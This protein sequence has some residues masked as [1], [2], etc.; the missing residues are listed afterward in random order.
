MEE[1]KESP[2]WPVVSV[3]VAARNEEENLAACLEALVHQDYRGKWEILVGD[4]Q[5]EDRTLHIAQEFQERFPCVRVFDQFPKSELT[6]GKSLIL[7]YLAEKSEGE[8]FL[9]CDADMLM[10][11]SW[12]TNMVSLL[13]AKNCAIVNGTTTVADSGIFSYLQAIDWLL[14]QAGFSFLSNFGFAFTAMGNNMGIT[15]EAYWKTGG[16]LKIPFSLT[17]DFALFQ[18]VEKNGGRLYHA[19]SEKVL[20]HTAALRSWKQW[21]LQHVRWMHGFMALPIYKQ[22]L[23]Y[24]FLALYPLAFLS[25]LTKDF[26]GGLWWISLFI[27]KFLQ[28][29]WQLSRIGRVELLLYLPVYQLIWWPFYMACWLS[30]GFSPRIEW[31]GRQWDN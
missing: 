5:S 22:S 27:L 13:Q 14:P 31:K 26:P 16:Y 7:G 6:A 3:W 29:A 25:L 9:I 28:D 21:L 30:Y 8:I 2:K 23:L 20:G 24:G 19:Y 18:E 11:G 17:E 1:F 12:I 4:D 15:Q 10:P